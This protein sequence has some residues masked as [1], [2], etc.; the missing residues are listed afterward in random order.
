MPLRLKRVYEPPARADGLRILAER[1]WPRGLTKEAAAIDQWMKTVAPSPALRRWYGHDPE[2]W[3]EFRGRYRA[4]LRSNEQGLSGLRALAAKRTVTFDY[5][6]K[7]E[8]RSS[9]ALLMAYL[10]A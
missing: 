4:E 3:P 2:K 1:L 5:A 7:D 6:A 10:E 9:A 8:A